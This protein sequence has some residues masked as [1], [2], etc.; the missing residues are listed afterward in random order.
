MVSYY[1]AALVSESDSA[2]KSILLTT[3][4]REKQGVIHHKM[5][6]KVCFFSMNNDGVLE[7]M[8]F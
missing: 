2:C 1:V 6:R 5:K 8:G 7:E 4:L 3:V